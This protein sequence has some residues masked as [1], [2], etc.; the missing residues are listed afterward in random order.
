MAINKPSF[1]YVQPFVLS[2]YPGGL[3]RTKYM[4]VG[5]LD[6]DRDRQYVEMM[7][8]A[9][10]YR[11]GPVNIVLGRS[12]RT[13]QLMAPKQLFEE[14]GVLLQDWAS[15]GAYCNREDGDDALF[16]SACRATHHTDALPVAWYSI[17]DGIAWALSADVLETFRD[18]G[19]TTTPFG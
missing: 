10:E 5:Q 16:V 15:N 3:P 7:A 13:V 18:S 12:R 14:C 19:Y 17:Y 2:S 11:H 1:A 4:G 9:N 8:H 6:W